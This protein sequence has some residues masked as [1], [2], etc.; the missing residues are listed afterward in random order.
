MLSLAWNGCF[1]SR[2]SEFSTDLQKSK[3]KVPEID[4]R[5]HFCKK[6]KKYLSENKSFHLYFMILFFKSED[7]VL[8][9]L[10]I[11]YLM[12]IQVTK[13]FFTDH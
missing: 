5:L 1:S 9:I 2:P 12:S 3:I 10:L 6:A 4:L 7:M 13:Q 8:E 11:L